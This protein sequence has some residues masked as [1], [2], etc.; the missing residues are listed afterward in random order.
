MTDNSK[1][2]TEEWYVIFTSSKYKKGVMRWIKKDF[3]HVYAMKRSPGEQFWTV[4]DPLLSHTDVRLICSGQWP[5]PRLY[6]G[7]DS[8]VLKVTA[9]ITSKPRW[10]LCVFNCV[11][12]V[13]SLLGIKSFWT[14]T[15]W[16][17]YKH[18][19]RG[20]NNE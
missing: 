17:L 7:L 19:V 3:S 6:A 9:K 20:D 18:L 12:V 1:N 4:I 13:K 11:E 8:V 15:P 14:W 16:Q 2:I 10:T 5:H